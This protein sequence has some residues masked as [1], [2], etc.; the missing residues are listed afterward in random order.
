[1]LTAGMLFHDRYELKRRLG[2]GGFSE[3][4]LA[5]DTK[6]NHDVAVKVY[7]SGTGLDDDAVTLFMQEFSLVYDLNHTNLLKPTT[8]DEWS[9]VPYLILPYCR[10]GSIYKFISLRT[11]ISE[12]QC[13]HLLH[14]VA[15][16]LAF[17][18]EQKPPIIHRDIK[19]DNI[20]ISDNGNYMITDFGISASIRNTI[21]RYS[22]GHSTGTLAYMAPECFSAN[23]QPVMASDIW[24]L[25]ATM[26]EVM[27]ADIPP[28]GN[29]G[30]VIQLN[31]GEI[32]TIEEPYSEEI[33]DIIYQCLAKEPWERPRALNIEKITYEHIEG[34]SVTFPLSSNSQP[35]FEP[36][37]Q[38]VTS[39]HST[40]VIESIPPSDNQVITQPKSD[41]DL[42]SDTQDTSVVKQSKKGN[43]KEKKKSQP[44]DE[45]NLEME[46]ANEQIQSV[47]QLESGSETPSDVQVTHVEPPKRKRKKKKNV[48]PIEDLVSDIKM[49]ND[50]SQSNVQSEY[51]T[52]DQSSLLSDKPQ[53]EP[54]ESVVR[55]LPVTL[56]NKFPWVLLTVIIVSGILSGVLLHYIL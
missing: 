8:Y 39:P 34:I 33:K 49:P 38:P 43:R 48:Q 50:S 10:Q 15:A 3:V 5:L 6:V 32:P 24:A 51:Q 53:P 14:D 54:S 12:D 16:G 55:S 41:L 46:I 18:H 29:H 13:W 22:S 35:K 9:N 26:F 21:S 40:T 47:I 1:M 52:A 42:S 31:G 19:P 37:L 56:D 45:Q 23:P 4:W 25:G 44:L 27:T 36:T 2:R 17:L 30:G 7:A 28:F 11:H 20:L